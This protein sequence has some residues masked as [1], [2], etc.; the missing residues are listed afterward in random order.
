MN[1]TEWYEY[2]EEGDVL[3]VYF[4][5]RRQAWTIELT[6][7][8]MIAIDREMRNGLFAAFA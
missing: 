5:D 6:P 4:A 2:D 8:I 7:N 3:D 1:Q